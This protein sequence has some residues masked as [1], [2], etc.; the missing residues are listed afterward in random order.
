MRT[1]SILLPSKLHVVEETTTKGSYEIEGLYPGYGHTLGNSL[2]RVILSSLPGAAITLVKI[3]G[4][5]H[6]YATIDGIRE[7]AL[8]IIMNLKKVRF[9]I[10]GDETTTVTLKSS[11]A[12]MVT[13]A[14]IDGGGIVEVMNPD[15]YICE[16][17][18]KNGSIDIEMVVNRGVGYVPREMIHGEKV[19]IGTIA[20]DAV[21]TPIRKVRYEVENMRVG[22][23]TDHNRLRMMIETDGSMTPREALEESIKIM[24]EQFRTIL[25]LPE[26]TSSM[27]AT[28]PENN[29][30]LEATSDNDDQPEQAPDMSDVLKTRIESLELSTRTANALAEANIRTIGGLV[31][32]D[33]DDLLTLE[34]IGNKGVT[35]IVDALTKLDVALKAKA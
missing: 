15:Q 5:D 13:A 14:A 11:G 1:T 17:T 34:G 26:E 16:I 23:R 2:R 12:G 7:D 21:Y 27:D 24:M 20:M 33:E 8:N 30:S 35:E 4:V 18:A 31:K 29:A 19:S 28:A 6:E 32:K 25:D 10:A 22:D 9:N 3:T